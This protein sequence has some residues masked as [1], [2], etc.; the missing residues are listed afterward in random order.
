VRGEEEAAVESPD[1]AGAGGARAEGGRKRRREKGDS[2]FKVRTGWG[3]DQVAITVKFCAYV[4]RLLQILRK[5]RRGLAVIIGK[6]VCISGTSVQ[7]FSW[8]ER[9][10]NLD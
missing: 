8:G 1:A 2:R 10:S 5:Q 9:W 7:I 6:C 4:T 3:K